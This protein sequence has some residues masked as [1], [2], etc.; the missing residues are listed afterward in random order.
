M[1]NQ[2]LEYL[3]AA[4][5]TLQFTQLLDTDDPQEIIIVRG[6]GGPS[7]GYPM[8]RIDATFQIISQSQDRY[9]AEQN[10]LSVYNY[11]QER[12]DID[13]PAIPE[14]SLQILNVAKISANQYPSDFTQQASGVYQWLFN[15]TVVFSNKTP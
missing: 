13:L 6:T 9:N 7:S 15:I 1:I 4:F 12:F 2:L 10:A 3:R 8:N 14:L 11:V 5:P